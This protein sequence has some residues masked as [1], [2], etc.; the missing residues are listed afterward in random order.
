[1]SETLTTL[2]ESLLLIGAISAGLIWYAV[3]AG[4]LESRLEDRR[5]R[6]SAESSKVRKLYPDAHLGRTGTE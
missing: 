2:V 6:S 5:T 4:R 3:V 1:M